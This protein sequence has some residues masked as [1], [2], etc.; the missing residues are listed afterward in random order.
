M[1]ARGILFTGEMVNA[2]LEDRKVMTRRVVKRGKEP[3]RLKH[4]SHYLQKMYGVSPPPDPVP[5]GDRGLWCEVGPDYPDDNSDHVKCPYGAEGDRLWVRETWRAADTTPAR[6]ILDVADPPTPVIFRADEHD[7]SCWKWKPGIHLKRVHAR[8]LLELTGVQVER[9]QE[10]SEE[11]ALAEGFAPGDSY[12]ARKA[13]RILWVGI[14][15]LAS[16]EA[17]PLVW[18]LSF[19][20]LAKEPQTVRD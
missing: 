13:F 9:A 3:L 12:S 4:S 1:K 7:P 16:W 18:V 15:G 10:I 8:I 20:V 17:N 2:I 5:F 19:K 11:D 6:S 14:N